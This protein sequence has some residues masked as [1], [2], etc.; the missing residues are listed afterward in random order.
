MRIFC[1]S[2]VQLMC[3]HMLMM[4]VVAVRAQLHCSSAAATS[5]HNVLSSMPSFCCAEQDGPAAAGIQQA[6]GS[7]LQAK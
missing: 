5:T 3:C 7:V 6:A 1:T 4:S 2:A